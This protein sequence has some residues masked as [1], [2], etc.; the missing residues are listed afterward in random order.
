MLDGGRDFTT[1]MGNFGVSGP[2]KSAGSFCCSVRGK[3]DHSILNSDMT[4]RLLQQTVDVI[5]RCPRDKSTPLRCGL[6][7]KLFNHLLLLRITY[8]Y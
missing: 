2:L 8:T 4:A 5:L 1:G 7:S 3:K 6:L